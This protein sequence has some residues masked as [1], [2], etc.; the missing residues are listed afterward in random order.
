MQGGWIRIGECCAMRGISL[1]QWGYIPLYDTTSHLK[2]ISAGPTQV[3]IYS[4]LGRC[5]S[6]MS[7]GAI[8]ANL[9]TDL[10]SC[11]FVHMSVQ[12][13]YCQPFNVH[14]WGKT[15]Q[16]CFRDLQV[17]LSGAAEQLN[18]HFSC[19]CERPSLLERTS[20]RL[21][22]PQQGHGCGF[23]LEVVV[24]VPSLPPGVLMSWCLGQ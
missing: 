7:A 10:M 14:D 8:S 21:L 11:L 12:M 24:L 4:L 1:L 17:G 15:H 20:T 6:M 16:N 13:G 3:H 9:E 23:S 19:S 22:C 5:G 18:L 2:S